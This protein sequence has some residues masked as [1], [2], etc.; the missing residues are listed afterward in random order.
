MDKGDDR[1]V[2]N[3]GGNKFGLV[4]GVDFHR[5]MLWIKSV[6]THRE[7]DEGDWK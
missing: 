6:L 7:Y 2:F 3:I 5:R 4:A 1:L